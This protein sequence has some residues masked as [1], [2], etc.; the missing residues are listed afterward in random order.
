MRTFKVTFVK[1]SAIQTAH[2][3]PLE[4]AEQTITSDVDKFD[5][6]VPVGYTVM[7]ITEVM[8]TLTIEKKLSK[9]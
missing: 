4:M 9:L 5:I 2:R 3:G 7:Q 6:P 1:Q 8:E